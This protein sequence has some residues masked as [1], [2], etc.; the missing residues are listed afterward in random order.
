[1][2]RQY[3]VAITA[4]AVIGSAALACPGQIGKVMF[5]DTF[6]DD[7]GGWVLGSG[8]PDYEIKDGSLLM[9]PN[10][11]GADEKNLSL[12]ATNVTFPMRDADYCVE[13]NLPKHPGN[14]IGVGLVFFGQDQDSYFNW[15]AFTDGSASLYKRASGKWNELF[16]DKKPPTGVKLEPDSLNSLRVLAKDNKLT[17]FLNGSQVKV[18]RAQTPSGELHFGVYAQVERTSAANPVIQVKHFKVTSGD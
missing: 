11:R 4:S 15:M 7:S 2:L 14:N 8:P 3:V 1:M 6:S 10:P 12:R 18:I 9:R 13:F 17:L 16:N 5:E